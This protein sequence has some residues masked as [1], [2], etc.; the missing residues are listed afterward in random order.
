MD[1]EKRI[2]MKTYPSSDG[3]FIAACDSSLVESHL[4]D[5]ALRL[6]LTE[7]FFGREDVTEAVFLSY[8]MDAV[9]GN[10]S[11]E[12]AV[13]IAIKAGFVDEENIL[14]IEGVPHAQFVRML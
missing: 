7:D 3:V 5:G 2:R 12:I 1:D 9:I 13:G 4:R 11:G 10:L 14:Y 6:D 8:L